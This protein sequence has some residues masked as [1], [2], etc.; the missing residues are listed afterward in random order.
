MI[1]K[2]FGI[3]S[4]V[5]L[6]ELVTD[7][8]KQGNIAILDFLIVA[9]DNEGA[10]SKDI[11]D[12]GIAAASREG[13]NET[14][15]YLK[16]LEAEYMFKPSQIPH[17][18]NPFDQY[19]KFGYGLGQPQFGYPQFGQCLQPSQ[20]QQPAVEDKKEVAENAIIIEIQKDLDEKINN[21]RITIEE[22]MSSSNGDDIID[23]YRGKLDGL[24]L[25]RAVVIHNTLPSYRQKAFNL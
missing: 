19:P 14:V 10:V 17:G 23:Y 5:P 18:Q 12:A 9:K 22:L 20:S 8:A 3:V 15:E 4:M 1:N 24:E 2:G 6:M 25:A 21:L 7:A 11:F 16:S 13:H